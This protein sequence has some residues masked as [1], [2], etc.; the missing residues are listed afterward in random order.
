MFYIELLD[1]NGNTINMNNIDYSFTLELNY[2]YN[3]D[4]NN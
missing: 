1:P 3:N 2:L 4:L